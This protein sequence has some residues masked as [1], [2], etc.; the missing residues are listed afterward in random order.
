MYNIYNVK[1]I[2]NTV[3]LFV[4][5]LIIVFIILSYLKH[6]TEMYLQKNEAIKLC[7]YIVYEKVNNKLKESFYKN[8]FSKNSKYVFV[9]L[10]FNNKSND[11]KS[12]STTA[13]CKFSL[14]YNKNHN[15]N[16]DILL[17]N[18]FYQDGNNSVFF[19]KN[20]LLKSKR[21]N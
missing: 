9:E 16:K 5:T 21:F 7:E 8:S 6:N 1:N 2:T 11:S 14:K 17:N 18:F 3:L 12:V 15:N 4:G 19:Y 20:V 10:R 13:K